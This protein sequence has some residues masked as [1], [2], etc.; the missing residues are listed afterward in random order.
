MEGAHNVI[1]SVDVH[2]LV[3]SEGDLAATVLGEEDGV[4]NSDHGGSEGAGLHGLAGADGEDLT[5]VKELI[6]LL[7][8]DDAGFGLG[9]GFGLTHNNS[10]QE[11]SEGFESDHSVFNFIN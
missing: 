8:E 2:F 9:N 1:I 4:A 3:I 10:V 11:R 7:A 6:L 5:E